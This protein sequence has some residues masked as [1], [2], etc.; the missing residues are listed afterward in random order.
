MRPP[1]R[2]RSK[3]N[4][5]T[6]EGGALRAALLFVREDGSAPRRLRNSP[7]APFLSRKRN[8]ESES[9]LAALPLTDL[10]A[11]TV[12]RRRSRQ[13]LVA[14]NAHK[15]CTLMDPAVG[16][17]I[18]SPSIARRFAALPYILRSDCYRTALR[19]SVSSLHLPCASVGGR[20]RLFSLHFHRQI[21]C[22]KP[23]GGRRAKGS[24]FLWKT[25]RKN[26]AIYR[27]CIEFSTL[28]WYNCF[29]IWCT[30]RSWKKASCL[31]RRKGVL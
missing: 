27:I 17:L 4:Y 18:A 14:K 25:L 1:S 15:G 8:G 22:E 13:E 9:P 21:P 6:K 29:I 2:W 23:R 16:K 5:P 7:R 19:L 20:W 3:V 12:L 30:I 31:H 11:C 28:F 24:F 26:D 10:L